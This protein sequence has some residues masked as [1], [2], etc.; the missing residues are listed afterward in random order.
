MNVESL[1]ALNTVEQDHQLVLDKMRALKE[2]VSCL[3]EPG[4]TGPRRALDRLRDL[5]EYFATHFAAHL[6]EEEATLFPFLER[7]NPA[8]PEL[9][10]RLRRE[11]GEIRRKREEFGNCL[12][13]ASELEDDLPRQVLRD[14]LDYGWDLWEFL[15]HHA[16]LETQAVHQCIGRSLLEDVSQHEGNGSRPQE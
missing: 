15:D 3:L 10:A 16:H 5:N 13:V 12:E 9:V 6:E 1:A 11:H 2:T 7:C 14:L 4:D 8:G